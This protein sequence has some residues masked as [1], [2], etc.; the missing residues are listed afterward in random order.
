MNVSLEARCR[1]GYLVLTHRKLGNRV[2][3]GVRSRALVDHARGGILRLYRHVGY[4]GARGVGSGSGNGDDDA[5]D[6]Q[7]ESHGEFCFTRVPALGGMVG[8][9]GDAACV[10][11]NG[12]DD[13]SMEVK[14]CGTSHNAGDTIS[15]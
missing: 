12:R 4:R 8:D 5:S 11:W 1:H 9:A 13:P 14:G 7:Q 3:A 15:L 2:V 10:C 6:S